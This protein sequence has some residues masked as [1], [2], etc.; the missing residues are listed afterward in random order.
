MTA[1]MVW[2]LVLISS[3][4]VATFSPPVADYETCKFIYD[5]LPTYYGREMFSGA[6][7]TAKCIQ[8]KVVK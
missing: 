3:N 5:N 2:V 6:Y 1:A 4:G 7:G 8:I